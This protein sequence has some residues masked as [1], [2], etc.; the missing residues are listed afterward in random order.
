MSLIIQDWLKGETFAHS[1]WPRSWSLW[2]GDESLIILRFKFTVIH[3]PLHPF[4][5]VNYFVRN[6]ICS[7]LSILKE[8]MFSNSRWK[9]T[10]WQNANCFF[11]LLLFILLKGVEKNRR[12]PKILR[13]S[14]AN[15]SISFWL[16]YSSFLDMEDNGFR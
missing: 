13:E 6:G 2:I 15:K 4:E 16:F 11:L 10:P 12:L 14:Q 5:S 7:P 8:F 3:L 1:L 9:I